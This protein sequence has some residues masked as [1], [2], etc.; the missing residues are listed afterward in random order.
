MVGDCFRELKRIC[1]QR[2]NQVPQA[3]GNELN[4]LPI[5]RAQRRLDGGAALLS[6]DITSYGLVASAVVT[7]RYGIPTRWRAQLSNRQRRVLATIDLPFVPHEDVC[8]STATFVAPVEAILLD[9]TSQ[10]HL[11]MR[12]AAPVLWRVTIEDLRRR[13]FESFQVPAF[14]SRQAA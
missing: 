10:M 8:M 11:M 5:A 12:H 6:S 2:W 14:W 1:V 4:D 9:Q 3:L 13:A 7:G